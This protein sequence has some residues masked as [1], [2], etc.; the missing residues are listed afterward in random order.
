MLSPFLKKLLFTRQFSI[1]DGKIE[2]MNL[3]SL[4]LSP[5]FIL[6]IQEKDSKLIYNLSKKEMI[7]QLQYFKSKI[8]IKGLEGLKR[9][10]DI[11]ELLGF[12][13]IKI[14][15]IDKNKK[16]CVINIYDSPIAEK[17]IK[18]SKKK[19]SKTTCDFISGKLAGM[20]CF[21]FN[22]EVESKEVKCLSK[23]DDF[24]QFVIK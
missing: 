20:F 10:E 1:V 24:C 14:L 9:I 13:K 23:G 19:S 15:D 18:N 22:K 7:E 8:A 4:M 6:K 16:R 17:Y 11:Y 12:G 3:R 5:E 21:I 2:I